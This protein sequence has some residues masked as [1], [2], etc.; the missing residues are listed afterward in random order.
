MDEEKPK[1]TTP[2]KPEETTED[3]KTGVQPSANTSVDDTN[4][5]AKR[6]EEA[7]KDAREERLKS[8]DNYSKMKL[9]GIT[10]G[11]KPTEKKEETDEEYVERFQKGE[12]NPFKQDA[13]KGKTE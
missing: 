1:E 10:E 12:V 7:T 9:G 5:A 6:L 8:E 4:L 2:D 13:N 3:P 11:G